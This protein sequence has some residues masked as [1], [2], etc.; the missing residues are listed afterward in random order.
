MKH[1]SP[2]LMPT[3]LIC[4]T[5]CFESRAIACIPRSSFCDNFCYWTNSIITKQTRLIYEYRDA[6]LRLSECYTPDWNKI[7][8]IILS[9]IVYS[10]FSV[11]PC[12]IIIVSSLSIT[13]I[14]D[15]IR[16]GWFWFFSEPFCV[17]F[18]FEPTEYF[19]CFCHMTFLTQL[20]SA[21]N[22]FYYIDRRVHNWNNSILINVIHLNVFHVIIKIFNLLTENIKSY[23]LSVLFIKR[24]LSNTFASNCREFQ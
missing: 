13:T 23:Y 12:G 6:W 14:D 7:M 15:L 19:I 11:T 3:K 24:V 16:T 22:R 9:Q 17:C 18:C 2:T 5:K 20:N 1:A 8:P 4:V 10:C 21:T